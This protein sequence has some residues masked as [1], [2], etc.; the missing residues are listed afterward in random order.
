MSYK[1][2]T[3]VIIPKGFNFEQYISILES[4]GINVDIETARQVL[5]DATEGGCHCQD[6]DCSYIDEIEDGYD[7]A[8]RVLGDLGM[9]L[10]DYNTGQE[11][12]ASIMNVIDH[13][14]AKKE[15]LLRLLTE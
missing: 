3:Y 13:I 4:T 14:I 10:F 6:F 7:F 12:N 11:G 2:K 5:K 1:Y 9:I 8:I 15:I